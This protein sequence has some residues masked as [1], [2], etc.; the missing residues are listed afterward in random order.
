MTDKLKKNEGFSDVTQERFVKDVICF[1]AK[2][3]ETLVSKL[4]LD[5]YEPPM[6]QVTRAL[7]V[8]V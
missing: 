4:H 2:D 7:V 6:S 8:T 3:Y 1:D 5:I